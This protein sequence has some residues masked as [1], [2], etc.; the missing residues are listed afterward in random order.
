MLLGGPPAMSRL[1]S[2]ERDV[3]LDRLRKFV[4]E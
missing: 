1:I 4:E 3:A 2:K